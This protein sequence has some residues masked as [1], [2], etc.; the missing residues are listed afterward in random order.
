MKKNKI[1][2]NILAF[3]ILVI[4]ILDSLL[5]FLIIP[6]EDLTITW[7]SWKGDID[8]TTIGVFNIALRLL[9]YFFLAFYPKK[10][11]RLLPLLLLTYA[12]PT[13]YLMVDSWWVFENYVF[14]Y[15]YWLALLLVSIGLTIGY[16]QGFLKL[17]SLSQSLWI[18][19]GLALTIMLVYVDIMGWIWPYEF[20]YAFFQRVIYE[21]LFLWVIYLTARIGL[22]R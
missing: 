6:F 20:V 4:F 1:Q 15:G 16:Y 18:T 9:A 5:H 13:L 19:F 10:V 3:S 17:I 7:I 21:P 14:L 8:F 12:I 2:P 22:G 11:A